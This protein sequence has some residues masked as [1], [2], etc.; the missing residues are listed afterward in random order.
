MFPSGGGRRSEKRWVSNM[1]VQD[2]YIIAAALVGDRENDDPDEQDFAIPYMNLL[3]QE[4]LDTENTM[5]MRDGQELLT[6]AP[7]VTSITDNVPYHDVLCRVAFP[8]G[9]AWQY[10]QE[11]GNLS[12][13][14]QY[15]NMFVDTV[16]NN[17]C[18]IARKM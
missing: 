7:T 18:F 16:D 4:A 1:T 14:A 13:S 6:V 5:R 17:R 11:A 12:L 10:Q 8:Y 15:R 3:M 9:L 2:I